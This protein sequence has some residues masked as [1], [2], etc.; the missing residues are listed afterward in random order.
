MHRSWDDCAFTIHGFDKTC[1]MMKRIAR[2]S[3][4]ALLSAVASVNV[5]AF[6]QA[7][8][9][10]NFAD[11][12]ERTGRPEQLTLLD[13]FGVIV[14]GIHIPRP[15]NQ[16]TPSDLNLSFETHRFP[17]S[18]GA[19]LE[20]WFVPGKDKRAIVALFHGYGASKSTLLTAAEA[21]YQLGYGPLLV[22]FYGSGGSSGSGTMLGVKEADDVV[23][24]VDYTRRTWPKRRIVL[25]GIS[26]G[27]A[28]LLRAVAVHGIKPDAIII[29]ATFDS[30]LNAGKNRFRAMG[31][32]GSPLAELLLFWG[33][34]QNGFNLFAHNPIDY[35]RGVS[36]P[37]LILHGGDD[38]RATPEQ[39][40]RIAYAMGG[41]ARFIV[42]AGLPHMPIVEAKPKE[43]TH[44]VAAFLEPIQ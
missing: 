15:K 36:E 35:A 20:A 32:P 22:D 6:M 9:M 8:A 24:T 2:L 34:V 7:R 41:H 19:T 27:G 23:A 37:A 33:S 25:Y 10:T 29:E 38:R 26:M 13:K 5:L 16:L 44:D 21:F 42:Y 31:L 39:A 3:V 17:N 11:G 43:W 18:N 14:S 30:L 1:F 4:A 40:R 12:G 28:A